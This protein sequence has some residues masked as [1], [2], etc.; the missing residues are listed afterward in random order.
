MYQQPQ[1]MEYSPEQNSEVDNNTTHPSLYQQQQQTSRGYYN[2][3]NSLPLQQELQQ[4]YYHS[5][6]N[7]MNQ[8]IINYIPPPNLPTNATGYHIDPNL[9]YCYSH[10]HLGDFYYNYNSNGWQKVQGSEED[11]P[12][13]PPRK[14]SYYHPYTQ[15]SC[16]TY[17]YASYY[18]YYLYHNNKDQQ[19]N[20]GANAEGNQVVATNT[21]INEA[22]AEN[23]NGGSVETTYRSKL[24]KFFQMG[25]V[26]SIAVLLAKKKLKGYMKFIGVLVASVVG[27]RLF[28]NLTGRRYRDIKY[29]EDEEDEKE[30]EEDE[31]DEEE[32]DLVDTRTSDFAKD[33]ILSIF[34]GIYKK[35]SSRG[36]MDIFDRLRNV[37]IKGRGGSNS[38]MML[39]FFGVLIFGAFQL[40]KSRKPR[41]GLYQKI[42]N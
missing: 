26:M 18:N 16:P 15:Q 1:Y 24:K 30:D 31:E 34:D 20:E 8:E 33:D 7:N 9:G 13:T 36:I 37:I 28:R 25:F 22:F 42:N 29:E 39:L 14:Y 21:T 4:A 3:D 11:K 19:G 32:K 35:G 27:I 12:G 23:K 38:S 6:Q 17:P 10:P 5:E 40:F 41:P 2:Y